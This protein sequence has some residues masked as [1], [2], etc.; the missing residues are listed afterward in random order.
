MN[1]LECPQMNALTSPLDRQGTLYVDEVMHSTGLFHT[2]GNSGLYRTSVQYGLDAP[3]NGQIV[4]KP[5]QGKDIK[6][7]RIYN[8][9]VGESHLHFQIDS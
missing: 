8:C 6:I 3:S 7:E 2:D 1:N 5:D 9:P 4:L